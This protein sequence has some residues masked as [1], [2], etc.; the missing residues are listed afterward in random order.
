M[1][2]RLWGRRKAPVY[3]FAAD[4]SIDEKFVRVRDELMRG[5]PGSDFWRTGAT[6]VDVRQD[7]AAALFIF[8]W[9][10]EAKPL[11]LKIDLEDTSEEFYYEEPVTS[12]DEWLVDLDVYIM[13]SIGTGVAQ[14]ARRIDRGEYIELVGT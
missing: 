5:G 13:V 1:A 2:P 9:A 7:G 12:F 10:D 8:E 3:D 4:P 11:A 6:L 14:R